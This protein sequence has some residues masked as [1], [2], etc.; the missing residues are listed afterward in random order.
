MDRLG[1]VLETVNAGIGKGCMEVFAS[2]VVGLGGG[3]DTAGGGNR[4][5]PDGDVHAVAEHLILVG[6][7]V[8]HVDAETELH[9]PVR[10][11]LAVSFGHQRLHPDRRLDSAD[12]AGKFQQKTIAGVLHQPAAMI[13]NDRIDRTSVRLERGVGTGLVGAHHPRVTCDVSADD[14]R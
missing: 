4:L 1:Y 3:G 11:Q 8:A 14:C 9:D 5:E 13:E 6:H 2:L 12:D 10:G 7:H